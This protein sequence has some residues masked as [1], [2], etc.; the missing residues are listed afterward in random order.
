MLRV[1][2]GRDARAEVLRELHAC[3]PDRA[4]GAVD[5]DA[6][7]FQVA[8]LP[9]AREGEAGTVADRRRFVEGRPRRHVRQRTALPHAD[10]LGMRAGTHAEHAVADVELGDGRADRLDLAG[11]FESEDLPLRPVEPGEETRDEDLGAAESAIRP[12]D[13]G[14][15][16]PDEHF[17]RCGDGPLDVCDPEDV[18]RSVAVVDDCSHVRPFRASFGSG[19][20]I[21]PPCLHI[22]PARKSSAGL[23]PDEPG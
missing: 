5:E 2:D 20:L 15:V 23:P 10:E 3:R 11:E 19:C 22:R 13:G 18:R 8:G 6:P 17:V 7:P 14:G 1:A 9:Q 4:G 21:G 12:R 16:N